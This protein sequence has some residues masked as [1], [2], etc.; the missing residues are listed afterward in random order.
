MLL[1]E[2]ETPEISLFLSP[3]KIGGKAMWW[4]SKKGAICK[5]GREP[6]SVT[7]PDGTLILDCQLLEVWEHKCL[8]SHTACSILLLQ[9]KQSKTHVKSDYT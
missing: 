5:R 3:L 4:H 1:L 6:S 7:N 9:P 8:L 2:E